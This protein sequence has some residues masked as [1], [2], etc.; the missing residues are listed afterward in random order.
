MLDRYLTAQIRFGNQFAK[1]RHDNKLCR[2]EAA[3]DV[4]LQTDFQGLGLTK[5]QLTAVINE[6]FEKKLAHVLTENEN[7]R[8]KAAL[9]GERAD[10]YE[11]ET[12][13]MFQE[14]QGKDAV[15]SFDHKTVVTS[16]QGKYLVLA[17]VR[18]IAKETREEKEQRP[19]YIVGFEIVPTVANEHLK[20]MLQKVSK[21]LGEYNVAIVAFYIDDVRNAP[22]Y[23]IETGVKC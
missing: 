7:S 11:E 16:D 4:V 13:K 10:L 22:F 19:D 9:D 15:I 14:L 21:K 5:S 3:Y 8:A 2:T 12:N 23:V 20:K 17:I 1:T 18:E 6:I